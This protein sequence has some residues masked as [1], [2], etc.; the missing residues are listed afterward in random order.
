MKSQ[1]KKQAQ[2][3]RS[4]EL[5]T[6]SSQLFS[7]AKNFSEYHAAELKNN[8]AY[9]L[10]YSKTAA[11]QDIAQLKALQSVVATE[12]N[13]RMAVYQ[14]K[15]KTIL[16]QLGTK[17]NDKHL[18]NARTVLSA[19]YKD[20]KKKIPKGAEQLGQVAHEIADAGINAFKEG[21]KLVNEAAASAEKSIKKASKKKAIKAK[22]VTTKAKKVATKA[23]KASA[24]KQPVK[25]VTAKKVVA[26][27]VVAKKARTK[28]TPLGPKASTN[29]AESVSKEIANQS[30]TTGPANT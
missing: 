26:K 21:C 25:K 4:K 11:H 14:V 30:P 28:A 16:D 9:A 2:Q 7:T 23:K 22:K 15:V 19:W 10:S 13:K 6:L 17:S 24:K 8:M 18:K 12:A 27:K 20:A 3:Q 1:D 29:S 5:F